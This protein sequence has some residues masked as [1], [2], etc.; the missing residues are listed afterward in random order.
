MLCE[1]GLGSEAPRKAEGSEGLKPSN[2]KSYM[3][4]EEVGV[5]GGAN[6]KAFLEELGGEG[7]VRDTDYFGT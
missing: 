2:G 5:A 1:G 7:L 4:N 3:P 6:L